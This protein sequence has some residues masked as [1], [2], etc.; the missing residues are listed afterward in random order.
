MQRLDQE[1]SSDV[2]LLYH[3]SCFQI[4]G[5]GFLIAVIDWT[6]VTT[7]C[8]LY[9]VNQSRVTGGFVHVSFM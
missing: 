9:R 1:G 8:F 2:F 6:D 4:H 3:M 5:I 7:V